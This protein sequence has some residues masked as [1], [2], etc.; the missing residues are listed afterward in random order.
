MTSRTRAPFLRD[1]LVGVPTDDAEIVLAS[2][3]F[4]LGA[5]RGERVPFVDLVLIGDA[6]VGDRV[7]ER[8]ARHRR[9]PGNSSSITTA[10][11]PNR[12]ASESRDSVS[13]S[14]PPPP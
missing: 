5:L 2:P 12:V 14:R 7:A 10:M 4:D 9:P 3:R 11:A 8:A 6:D 1:F 13:L